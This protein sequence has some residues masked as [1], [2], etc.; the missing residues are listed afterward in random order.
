MGLKILAAG[1]ILVGVGMVGVAIVPALVTGI[2]L[3]IGGI[4][5][6]AGY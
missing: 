6:I 5:V 1:L 2:L 4:G 3:I